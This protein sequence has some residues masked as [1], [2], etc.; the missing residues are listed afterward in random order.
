MNR[1]FDRKSY[2]NI[3][4]TFQQVSRTFLEPPFD[5]GCTPI[6]ESFQ[7]A[8]DLMMSRINN[9]SM[10]TFNRVV[11]FV[12]IGNEEVYSNHKLNFLRNEELVK[13]LV[14]IIDKYKGV[15]GCE[16]RFFITTSAIRKDSYIRFTL[17]WP[18]NPT[19][20]VQHLP[21]QELIDFV[22]F[23]CSGI[24][25]WFG[26]SVLSTLEGG[27]EFLGIIEKAVRRERKRNWREN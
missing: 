18:W 27:R 6:S 9:E 8:S 2:P 23:V 19:V 11:P 3:G 13:K 15:Q 20:E 16:V 22:V 21:K 24:G 1:N 4:L 10:E 5:T 17:Y 26:L 7:S 14:S 25:I 12:P